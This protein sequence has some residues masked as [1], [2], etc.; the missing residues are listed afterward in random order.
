MKEK[1]RKFAENAHRGQFRKTGNLPYI[2]HPD[3]VAEMLE[4][5]G[6]NDELVCAGYL[7]D[8]V[9]DTPV[10]IDEIEKEF[11]AKVADLVRAH[12]E[13]KTKSWKERKRQTIDT[14][15]SAELDLKM[16]IVADRLDNLLSLERSLEKTGPSV[17]GMFNAGYEEQK[18]Y[19]EEIM[20]HM[21]TGLPKEKQPDLFRSFESAVKRIFNH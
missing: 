7:H 5:A 17:W 3:R 16:L 6:A 13:D 20:A 19:N 4:K 12:T 1:A 2:V 11:G 8:V 10:G 21:N 15:K 18:W 14:L 9:E